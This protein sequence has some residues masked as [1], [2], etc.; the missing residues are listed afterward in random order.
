MIIYELYSRDLDQTK[1]ISSDAL[2]AP[3]GWDDEQFTITRNQTY[4]GLMRQFSASLG[5]IEEVKTW[6]RSIIDTYGLKSIVDITKYFYNTSTFEKE[7]INKGVLNFES[8]REDEFFFD[9]NYE[10]SNYVTWIKNRENESILYNVGTPGYSLDG[11]TLPGYTSAFTN[12]TLY[13]VAFASTVVKMAYPFEVIN[14][15]LQR[16]MNIDYNPLRSEIFGRT[17]LTSNGFSSNYVGNGYFSYFMITKG[18]IIR[19]TDINLDGGSGA[20]GKT[21]LNIA[22]KKIFE[23]FDKKKRLGMGTEVETGGDGI[24]RTY[25]R[26]EEKSYFYQDALYSFTVTPDNIAELSR[27]P[28]EE[29]LYS[30]IRA[31]QTTFSKD[32]DLGLTEYVN[33][34]QYS[35][36]VGEFGGELDLSTEYR[37]DG[38]TIEKLRTNPIGAGDQDEIEGDENIFIIDCYLD[39]A[40]IKSRNDSILPDGFSSISGIYGTN[41]LYTNLR[42]RGSQS[43]YDSGKWIKPGMALYTSDVLRF[44]DAK[45]LSKVVTQLSGS[46]QIV[47]DNEDI[48]I[49]DLEDGKIQPY[50]IRFLSILTTSQIQEIIDN[51]YKLVKYWDYISSAYKYGWILEVSSDLVDKETNYELIEAIDIDDLEGAYWLTQDDLYWETQDGQPW[52]L[53]A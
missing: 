1:T 42:L 4:D 41:P 33:E 6:L 2:P 28:A 25:I 7:Q 22:F 53:S 24:E 15:I 30:N 37:A 43:I 48:N 10:D 44:Q 45:Q 32:E 20:D 21:N 40:T 19:G 49:S 26:I 31:G 12:V 29:Y 36:P 5:W 38:T 3:R 13:G 9:V 35:T 46:T 17:N 34:V 8:Y 50:K 16:I 27:E 11:T 14:R 51:P 18:L 39:G 52:L 47:T 23:F